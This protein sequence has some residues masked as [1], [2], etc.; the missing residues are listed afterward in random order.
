[1]KKLSVD[2]ILITIG[3]EYSQWDTFLGI[4]FGILMIGYR[5]ETCHYQEIQILI[6]H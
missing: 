6:Y 5:K 3:K 1:M 2:E 4:S